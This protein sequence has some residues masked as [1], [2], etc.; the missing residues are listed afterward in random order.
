MLTKVFIRFAGSFRAKK[1]SRFL[2]LL[3]LNQGG[4]H[5]SIR[6]PM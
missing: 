1:A 6:P 2:F 3:R 5:G 4:E